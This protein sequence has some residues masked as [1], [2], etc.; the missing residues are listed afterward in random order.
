[1]KARGSQV[2]TK[3]CRRLESRPVAPMGQVPAEAAAD[4]EVLEAGVA[5]ARGHPGHHSGE[6]PWAQEVKR[7][8]MCCRS[9]LAGEEQLSHLFFKSICTLF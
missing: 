5:R 8:Q 3:T 6:P 9:W 1:M 4:P 7:K 2:S